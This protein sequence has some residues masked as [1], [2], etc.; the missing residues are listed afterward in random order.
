MKELKRNEK[1]FI[2]MEGSLKCS[3]LCSVPIFGITR[4]VAAGPPTTECIG[5]LI[6]KLSELKG[7]GV[8]AL[9]NGIILLFSFF[10]ALPLCSGFKAK[11]EGK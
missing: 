7:V 3:G 2:G 6:D 4:M 10:A 9:V 8:V 1:F 11:E 5:A